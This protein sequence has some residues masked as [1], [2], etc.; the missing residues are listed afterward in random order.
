MGRGT[1]VGHAAK[2]SEGDR[3]AYALSFLKNI[4]SNDQFI[5]SRRGTVRDNKF[6]E[7]G[8]LVKIDWDDGATG[9]AN[10][11]NLVLE[12]RMHLEKV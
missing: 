9:F 5:G 11:Q 10:Q 7:T 12:S 1:L 8:V 4:C 3:V 6:I 2:F